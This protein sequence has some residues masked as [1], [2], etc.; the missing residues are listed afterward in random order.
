M[1]VDTN[2]S[3]GAG[4]VLLTVALHVTVVHH[5]ATR[6]CSACQRGHGYFHLVFTA[7]LLDEAR[8]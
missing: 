1:R 7:T 4:C 2:A 8:R 6:I 3:E 5:H